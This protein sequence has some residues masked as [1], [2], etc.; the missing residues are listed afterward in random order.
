[1]KINKIKNNNINYKG[2]IIENK[3]L[4][5][6]KNRLTSEQT[7]AIE[8]CINDIRKTNDNKTF[9]Y[10]SLTVGNKII[11]KIHIMDIYGRLIK[12]LLFIEFGENPVNIFDKTVNLCKHLAN[13]K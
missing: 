6:L 13:V 11:S 1:M 2:Q 9:V 4:N 8:K 3:A 10:D 7:G 5:Q 12:L